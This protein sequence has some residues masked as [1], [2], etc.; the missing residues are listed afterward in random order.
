MVEATG[1]VDYVNTSIGVATASLF[2]IEASMHIPPGYAMYIPSAI[3]KAIDLPVVGV[4]RFKDPLQAERALAEGHCDL[5][6]VVRGQ[7]A[8]AEFAAK[9]RAGAT[10]EI[11]LCLSCNQECGKDGSTA[12]WGAREPAHGREHC[13]PRPRRAGGAASASPLL[14]AVPDGRLQAAIAPPHGI[15]SRIRTGARRPGGVGS[16]HRA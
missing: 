16:R 6:G 5:V 4:G 8:D 11:R 10:D 13:A 14:V 7:I 12:V 9:G 2:V 1:Q 3:R 15:G